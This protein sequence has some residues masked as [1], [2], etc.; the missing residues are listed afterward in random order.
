[1]ISITIELMAAVRNPFPNQKRKNKLNELPKDLTI[2]ELLLQ[3]G[4]LKKELEHLIPI[5]N[6]SRV[7]M[8]HQ[9]EDGDYIWITFPLG[10]GLQ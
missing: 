7:P 1:M 9:L 6:G 3:V 10:G 8:D 2:G 4:F 5:I